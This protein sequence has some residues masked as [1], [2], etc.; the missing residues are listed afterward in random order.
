[1]TKEQA[2]RLVRTI[3]EKKDPTLKNRLTVKLEPSRGGKHYQAKGS[4]AHV[5]LVIL[6]WP[7]HPKFSEIMM[8]G[9][10]AAHSIR[11]GSVKSDGLR[12]RVA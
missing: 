9:I 4:D 5:T 3:A 2:A 6:V 7:S 1:M 8:R 11:H 12:G 10:S